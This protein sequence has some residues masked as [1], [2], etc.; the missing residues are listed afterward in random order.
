M[1]E[2]VFSADEALRDKAF[3]IIRENGLTPSQVLNFFLQKIVASKTIPEELN[4]KSK[5]LRKYRGTVKFHKDGL[6]LQKEWRN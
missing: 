5:G 1:A 3:S 4:Q 6:E 2:I